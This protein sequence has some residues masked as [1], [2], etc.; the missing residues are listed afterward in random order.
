MI[1]P[2]P[3]RERKLLTKMS[4]VAQYMEM[5]NKNKSKQA[6]QECDTTIFTEY[7]SQPETY[8]EESEGSRISINRCYKK[9]K[10]PFWS[11]LKQLWKNDAFDIIH[12]EHEIFL[13]GG[14]QS[15]PSL[16]LFILTVR[17]RSACII[18]LH[19]VISKKQINRTFNDIYNVRIHPICIRIGFWLFYKA[20]GAAATHINVY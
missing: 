3:D 19:H 17:M 10:H 8:S 15:L 5:L 9:G 4:A 12:I 16:I 14:I 7:F 1:S 18:T 20:V 13:Y 2:Y 6:K 11:I